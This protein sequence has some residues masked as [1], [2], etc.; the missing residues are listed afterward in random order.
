MNSIIYFYSLPWVIYTSSESVFTSSVAEKCCD[1]VL[2]WTFCEMSQQQLYHEFGVTLYRH[3]KDEQWGLRLAGGSDLNSP[4][5]VIRVIRNSHFSCSV[6]L[7]SHSRALMITA[8]RD[9]AMNE[10]KSLQ[11]CNFHLGHSH[12]HATS[13]RKCSKSTKLLISSRICCEWLE[14]YLYALHRHEKMSSTLN[15][16]KQQL[17]DLKIVEMISRVVMLLPHLAAVWFSFSMI[18]DIISSK[19]K[20]KSKQI[21]WSVQ[22]MLF[23]LFSHLS[24]KLESQSLVVFVHLLIRAKIS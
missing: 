8:D 6:A 12:T 19:K 15:F 9:T 2:R 21:S 17:W 14:W 11:W 18:F 7:Q 3:R 24:M 10:N 22:L 20:I 16:R 13:S 23:S 1:T 5:I 4:L